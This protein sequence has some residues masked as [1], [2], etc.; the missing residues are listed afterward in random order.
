MN[1]AATN[2]D[3]IKDYQKK[4]ANNQQQAGY[5]VED[6]S[7]SAG[8]IGKIMGKSIFNLNN[9]KIF[10]GKAIEDAFKVFKKGGAKKAAKTAVD[11][12]S[13]GGILS[14]FKKVLP[15]CQLFLNLEHLELEPVLK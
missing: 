12:L 2:N 3:V 7:K 1:E 15:F 11:L 4:E 10:G 9:L 6:S 5:A 13:P 14:L 8:T